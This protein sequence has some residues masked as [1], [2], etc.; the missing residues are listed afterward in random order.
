[1]SADNNVAEQRADDQ[2][3]LIAF[4]VRLAVLVVGLIFIIKTLSH[5]IAFLTPERR[6]NEAVGLEGIAY[7][8]NAIF[9]LL[10]IGAILLRKRVVTLIV[11]LL[12]F[13]SF[14]VGQAAI[15]LTSTAAGWFGLKGPMIFGFIC[16]IIMIA[17]FIVAF[18][19]RES[20]KGV[21][22]LPAM[23]RWDGLFTNIGDYSVAL[24]WLV[25]V[26]SFA[27]PLS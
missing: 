8:T 11:H 1:M 5:A 13:I 19:K 20:P 7:I 4:I 27:N 25:C 14:N 21:S 10:S 22:S 23:R 18:V 6:V 15:G 12:F 9:A 3:D 2:T 17:M 24:F 16:P 26:F